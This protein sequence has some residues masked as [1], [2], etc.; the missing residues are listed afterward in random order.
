MKNNASYEAGNK[1]YRNI[2]SFLKA[3]FFG[4]SSKDFPD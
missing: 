3:F 1:V 4:Q 2:W